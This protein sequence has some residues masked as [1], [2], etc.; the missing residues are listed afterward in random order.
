[1]A[2]HANNNYKTIQF[3]NARHKKS[4]AEQ[5]DSKHSTHT[6]QLNAF[7]KFIPTQVDSKVVNHFHIIVLSIHNAE[8]SHTYFPSNIC[9]QFRPWKSHVIYQF[10][11]HVIRHHQNT[12]MPKA[13][14]SSPT[15]QQLNRFNFSIQLSTPGSNQPQ[16][17]YPM[18]TSLKQWS[19]IYPDKVAPT[20]GALNQ[21]SKHR[22]PPLPGTIFKR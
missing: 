3:D 21:Q 13:Y 9:N 12:P 1:M 10:Q 15:I 5:I 8:S 6:S 14:C 19:I 11:I 18:R 2:L 22:R 4:S 16:Q 17:A 7:L 20:L